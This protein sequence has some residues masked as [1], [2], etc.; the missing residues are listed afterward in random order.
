MLR[1]IIFCVIGGRTPGPLLYV[2]ARLEAVSGEV[3]IF[4]KFMVGKGKKC[5]EKRN[6]RAGVN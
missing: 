1:I 5:G 4:S 2:E 6:D 3:I